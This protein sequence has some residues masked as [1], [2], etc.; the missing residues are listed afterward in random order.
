VRSRHN[1]LV[2]G[3]PGDIHGSVYVGVGLIATRDTEEPILSLAIGL[4]TM[5]TGTTST[6]GVARIDQNHA[7][8][9]TSRLVGHEQSQLVKGPTR[10]LPALR[11]SNRDSLPNTLQVFKCECLTLLF[12]LVDK[13][14]TDLVVDLALKPCLFPGKLAQPPA[15]AAGIGLLEPLSM[16]K[17]SLA[18]LPYLCA[19]VLLA[20]R[21]GRKVD[22]AEINADNAHWFMGRRIGLRLRD[23]QIPDVR[24]PYQFRAAYLPTRVVQGAALEV[25]K[26]K[27]SN[28][29]TC[30]RVQA[31]PIQAHQ[32]VGAR[33][34]TDRAVISKRRTIG[35]L[36]LSGSSYCFCGFVSGTAGKL[37]AKSVDGARWTVD[38]V[39]QLVLVRDT[40]TPRDR[41][42]VGSGTIECLLR[43]AQSCISRAIKH[44]FTTYG[45]CGEGVTH[46]RIVPQSERLCKRRPAR[47][48]DS[49]MRR[50]R[51]SS[52]RL[53]AAVS[54]RGF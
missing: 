5:P 6:A 26:Y 18:H 30:D 51:N 8:A 25:T 20:V 27:L 14:L 49:S 38:N 40:F 36:V 34:V 45:T 54:L 43:L 52:A 23:V 9:F 37:R 21:V 44:D 19:A 12:G 39:M 42:A 2:D 50:F 11:A 33:I 46:K 35:A 31:H 7:H 22:Q 29:P 4:L 28:H 1:R 53:K 3:S 17:A 10:A 16:L 48:C 47:M 15:S 32:A 41:G 13:P 24:P